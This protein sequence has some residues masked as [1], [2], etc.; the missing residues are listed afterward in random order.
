[1]GL[2]DW[3]PGQIFCPA[4]YPIIHFSAVF[5]VVRNPCGASGPSTK[6]WEWTTC[7]ACLAVGAETSVVARETRELVLA[8]H[9]ANRRAAG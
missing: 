5:P 2:A 3:K 6:R 7:L 1:M 4:P 8:H 9:A